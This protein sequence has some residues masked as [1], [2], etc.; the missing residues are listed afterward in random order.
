ME[1]NSPSFMFHDVRIFKSFCLTQVPRIPATTPNRGEIRPPLVKST[2]NES[3][4]RL[5]LL[6]YSQCACVG[7][8]IVTASPI[9]TVTIPDTLKL[10]ISVLAGSAANIV[11]SGQASMMIALGAILPWSISP[12]PC[13]VPLIPAKMLRTE[14][15]AIEILPLNLQHTMIVTSAVSAMIEP[16]RTTRR[17]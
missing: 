2:V 15:T 9:I 5:R 3:N 11:S 6:S 17:L 7:A 16:N 4:V 12:G 1:F 8:Q 14:A 10:G 13:D